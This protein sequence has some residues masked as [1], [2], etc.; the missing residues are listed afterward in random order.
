MSKGPAPDVL[1]I[2]QAKRN[3][4]VAK[5]RVQTTANA[6]KQRL[7]PKALAAD[8]AETVREKTGAVGDAA[9]KRP[10]AAGAAAGV[11]A[12]ILFR[13]PVGRLLRLVVSRKAREQRRERKEAAQEAKWEKRAAKVA[14]KEDKRRAKEARAEEKTLR[15]D[16]E[17]QQ[18]AAEISADSDKHAQPSM[19]AGVPE[20]ETSRAAAG[21][22]GATSAKQE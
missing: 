12:L 9:R 20:D 16:P 11:A 17:R 21:G 15:R 7:A 4:A 14:R 19:R 10:A 1:E 8:A 2:E 18:R 22:A 13:K 6:L 3:A 5:D